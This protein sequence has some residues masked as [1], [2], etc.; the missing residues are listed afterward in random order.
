[1]LFEKEIYLELYWIQIYKKIEENQLADVAT[2]ESTSL[3]EMKKRN[4][5]LCEIDINYTVPQKSSLFS[6]SSEKT[7]LAKLIY[8]K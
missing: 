6:K 3:Q 1:M 2:D 4:G 7:Y 5:K 8:E